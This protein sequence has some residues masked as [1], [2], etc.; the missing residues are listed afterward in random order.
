MK[1]TQ[2]TEHDLDEAIADLNEAIAAYELDEAL[3]ELEE[4]LAEEIAEAM[5]N[6]DEIVIEDTSIDELVEELDEAISDL[7]T[8]LQ[9][10][11]ATNTQADQFVV[12]LGLD[13]SSFGA[14]NSVDTDELAAKYDSNKTVKNVETETSGRLRICMV[15]FKDGSEAHFEINGSN[16]NFVGVFTESVEPDSFTDDYT[17]E[18]A[19]AEIDEAIKQLQGDIDE[20]I[21]NSTT[22]SDAITTLIESENG[23]SDA[24]KAKAALIFTTEMAMARDEIRESLDEEYA[25]K[26]NEETQR[27][28][29]HMQAQLDKYL[30][31]VVNEWIATNEATLEESLAN[32]I[33]SDVITAIRRAFTENHIEI[34]HKDINVVEELKSEIRQ[35]QNESESLRLELETV[36]EDRIVITRDKIVS[37]AKESLTSVQADKLSRLA[38]KIDF[39]TAA[40]FENKVQALKEFYFNVDS[41]SINESFDD[42]ESEDEIVVE[43]VTEDVEETIDFNDIDTKEFTDPRMSSYVKAITT[44]RF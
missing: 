43:H 33:E 38:S 5:G 21:A 18:E 13:P 32:E 1:N 39:T 15:Q 30:D 10:L 3:T 34:P 19:R 4:T 29:E 2:F 31:Y 37:E 8:E 44:N 41:G 23:L 7:E 16:A 24:F 27:Y 12:S 17:L 11:E 6:E 42:Q 26:L 20:S 28:E 40:D 35:L 22:T 25:V 14:Q 9:L 36:N